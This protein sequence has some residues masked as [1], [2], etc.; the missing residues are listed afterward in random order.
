MIINVCNINFQLFN[1]ERKKSLLHRFN[2]Y[3]KEKTFKERIN[4]IKM[5]ESPNIEWTQKEK[6]Y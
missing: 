4:S 1:N 6:N 5:Y 3:K 2:K